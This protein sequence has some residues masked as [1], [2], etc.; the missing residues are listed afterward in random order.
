MNAYL[1]IPFCASICSYCD[2]TSFAGKESRVADY[3]RALCAEIRLS[4]LES[5]LET[6]YFGGGTPSLLS[7]E[8]AV[9]ILETLRAKAGYAASAEISMEANPETA[10]LGK[11]RGYRE[12]GV[13]RL[14]LGG[15]S[16]QREILGRLGRGH[17]WTAVEKALGLAREAG[18]DNVNLDLMFGLPGQSLPQFQETLRQAQALQPDHLSLYAL[19]VEEGTPLA[20]RVREGLE[21]PGEELVAD[22]YAWA[23]DF[24]AANG[25]EQYEV[26]NFAK[27]GHACRHNLNVWRG[28]DYFGFGISAVGTAQGIR[29]THGEDLEEYISS[30]NQK[31]CLPR[32]QKEILPPAT[33]RLEKI[34]L[35]L[36]TNEGVSQAELED[37]AHSTNIVYR[38]KLIEKFR[39]FAG[40]GLLSLAGGR[41][42]PTRDGF[43]VLNGILE[44]LLA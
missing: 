25:F 15:Q 6:V 41:F 21:V 43:F 39:F 17:D 3:V 19:Q 37:Y 30:L 27:P 20:Q 10:D 14:S 29:E 42:R 13:N 18:F 9:M 12:R 23:Q 32:V 28:Q 5:P 16:S 1:H 11:W 35:G 4:S 22:E 8:Q 2:F 38:E 26:S 33:R 31:G 40:K 7:P 34:M 44:T 24:L 36:R